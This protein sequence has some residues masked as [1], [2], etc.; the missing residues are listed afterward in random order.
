[1]YPL[2]WAVLLYAVY[3]PALLLLY[4]VELVAIFKHRKNSLFNS[5]FFRTFSALA[6]VN[7]TACLVGSFVFRLNLYPMVN[8][9]YGS[10]LKNSTYYLNC[11]SE[12]L[13]VFLAF[14]RFTTLYFPS[15]HDNF[16]QW[17]LGL[18]ITLCFLISIPPVSHLFDDTNS[19]A[20]MASIWFN[21]FIVTVVCNSISCILY[22]ACLIRLWMFS[23]A[24]NYTVERNFFLVGFLTMIFSLPYMAAIVGENFEKWIRTLKVFQLTFYLNLSIVGVEMDVNLVIFIAFQLPWLT[25]LKYLAPAPMLLLTNKSIRNAIRGLIMGKSGKINS[26]S[27]NGSVTAH[28]TTVHVSARL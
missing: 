18:G 1:M 5:S 11:L 19:F 13:G 8:G 6:V 3:V 21:M 26:V 7:I 25:D 2:D 24:R 17:A 12:F 28:P 10:M 22:G 20:E 14:N 15:L 16:W 9:F 4:V 23:V 27:K